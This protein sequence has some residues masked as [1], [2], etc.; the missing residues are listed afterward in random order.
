MKL[1]TRYILKELSMPFFLGL[2]LF[3]GILISHQ[4]FDL[5][6]L[7]INK[8]FALKQVIGFVASGI[9]TTFFFTV[10]MAVLLATLMVFGRLAADLELTVLRASGYPLHSFITPPLIAAFVLTGCLLG[11]R[12][13]G[14]PPLSRYQEKI[15]M[16]LEIPDPPGLMVPGRHLT[17]GSYTIFAENVQ[18]NKMENIFLEDNS[19]PNSPLT[20]YALEGQWEKIDPITYRLHLEDGTMHQ[21]HKT[22]QYR[23]IR[24]QSQTVQIKFNT[25][26]ENMNKAPEKTPPLSALYSKLSDAKTSYINYK[27]KISDKKP[28]KASRKRLHNLAIDSR[29]KSI[30]F[31]HELA[32]PFATLFL[33]FFGAPMGIVT[34]KIGKSLDFVLSLGIIVL[35]YLLLTGIEP[36]AINGWLPPAIA[37]WLPNTIYGICGGILFL[38]LEHKGH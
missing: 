13:Y 27:N 6:D 23:Q 26:S 28:T 20:I 10:P 17:I 34:S 1:V 37:M 16:E 8:G 35:Y 30:E 9:P 33:V 2:L 19:D 4:L 29:E 31:H 32:L 3:T 24:F 25:F 7:I 11:L 22:D 21:L 15:L 12:E 14:L 36:L 5:A 38:Y 18:G